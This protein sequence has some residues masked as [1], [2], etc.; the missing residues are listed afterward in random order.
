MPLTSGV[1][2]LWSVTDI[3]AA[4]R[5]NTPFAALFEWAQSLIS[6]ANMKITNLSNDRQLYVQ[7][8]IY[9]LC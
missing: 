3:T 8:G 7:T 4:V 5:L 1:G 2:Y 9:L 6:P